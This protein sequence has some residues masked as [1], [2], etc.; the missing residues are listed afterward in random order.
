MARILTTFRYLCIICICSSTQLANAAK[1]EVI[2]DGKTLAGWRGYQ[3]QAIDDHWVVE[4][5]AIKGSGKGPDI[6]TE[7]Q[8]GD[9]D[10]RFEWKIAPGGN[11]G[12]IYRVTE[13]AEQAYHTGPEYQVL[14]D[15]EFADSNNPTI[16]SSGLYALYGTEKK[17]LRPVGEYN[18][19]RIVVRGNV[20]QHWLNDQKVLECHIGSEDWNK[21]VAASK[22]A[23]WKRFGKNKKGHIALQSHGSPVWYRNITVTDLTEKAEASAPTG[24]ESVSTDPCQPV[25]KEVKR[26]LRVNRRGSRTRGRISLRRVFVKNNNR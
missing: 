1:R 26:R 25:I 13:D 17:E 7:K 16:L 10:L 15:G 24:D 9:F 12:V 21:K 20:I 3:K 4:D 22:F 5:G 6:V 18:V 23:Q 8:Y 19:S 11:S 2:F 14:D